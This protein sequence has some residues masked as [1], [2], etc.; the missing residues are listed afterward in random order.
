MEAPAT[1][2]S[3]QF[4]KVKMPSTNQNKMKGHNFITKV[5]ESKIPKIKQFREDKVKIMVNY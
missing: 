1:A 3:T 5:R 2:P 4:R